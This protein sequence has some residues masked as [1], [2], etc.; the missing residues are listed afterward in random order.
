MRALIRKAKDA[1]ERGERLTR[2]G[3]RAEH[4]FLYV[5]DLAD[6]CVFFMERDDIPNGLI[7]IGT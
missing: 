1:K 3:I 4:G 5:D 6:A 7:N 2:S